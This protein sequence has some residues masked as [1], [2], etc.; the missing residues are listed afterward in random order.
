MRVVFRFGEDNEPPKKKISKKAEALERARRWMEAWYAKDR[1]RAIRRS[2]KS[3]N[4]NPS[5][6]MSKKRLTTKKRDI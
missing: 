4:S 6:L 1:K 3:I 2:E 5:V